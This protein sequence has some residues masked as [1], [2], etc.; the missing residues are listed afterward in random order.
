MDFGTDFGFPASRDGST[1]PALPAARSARPAGPGFGSSQEVGRPS[2]VLKSAPSAMNDCY[3]GRGIAKDG[4]LKMR[5]LLGRPEPHAWI[6]GPS[7]G[8]LEFRSHHIVSAGFGTS[9]SFVYELSD[10]I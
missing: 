8:L 2:S 1:V 5:R 7:S 4:L 10:L 9:L 6:C 3:K